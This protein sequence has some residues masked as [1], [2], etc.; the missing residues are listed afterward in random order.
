MNSDDVYDIHRYTDEQLMN[1]LNLNNPTDHELEAKIL[2]MIRRYSNIQNESG[3]KLA[4]FFNRVYEHFF[5]TSDDLYESMETTDIDIDTMDTIEGFMTSAATDKMTTFKYNTNNPIAIDLSGASLNNTIDKRNTMKNGKI[6]Y[7]SYSKEEGQNSSQLANIVQTQPLEYSNDKTGLNPLIKQT[8]KRIVNIDSQFRNKAF[9]PLSTDFTFNLSEPLKDVLSLKLYS[10]QIPYTWYTINNNYGSNFLYL[11]GVTTGVDNGLQDYQITIPTGNYLSTDFSANINASIASIKATNP[12][13]NFGTTNFSFNTLNSKSTFT[14]DIQNIYNES[15][16]Q[17]EMDQT[18]AKYLQFQSQTYPLNTI[19]STNTPQPDDPNYKKTTF[20]V[21]NSINYF[22]V[23]HYTDPSNQ[24]NT[25]TSLIKDVFK[26]QLLTTTLY[27]G[28]TSYIPFVGTL[29]K[30]NINTYIQNGIQQQP[31]LD[32]SHSYVSYGLD[33]RNKYSFTISLQLNKSK[34]RLYPNSKLCIQFPSRDQY[35]DA[36]GNFNKY[37]SPFWCNEYVAFKQELNSWTHRDVSNVNVPPY[38]ISPTMKWKS[39]AMSDD[40]IYQTAAVS[41]N[42]PFDGTISNLYYSFDTGA[43]WRAGTIKDTSNNP[44]P[45]NYVWD[46]VVIAGTGNFQIAYSSNN[47]KL[48]FSID[49]GQT[50]KDSNLNYEWICLDFAN[51]NGIIIVAAMKNPNKVYNLL[52]DSVNNVLTMSEI[53]QITQLAHS[54]NASTTFTYNEYAPPLNYF[55]NNISITQNGIYQVVITSTYIYYSSDT[56]NTWAVT[57]LVCNGQEIDT[58][59]FVRISYNDTSSIIYTTISTKSQCYIL[60][61]SQNNLWLSNNTRAWINS[62]QSFNYIQSVSVSSDSNVQV[63]CDNTYDG[64]NGQIYTS[65]DYGYTWRTTVISPSGVNAPNIQW[66]EVTISKITNG[67]YQT[68]VGINDPSGGVW[69]LFYNNGIYSTTQIYT[70]IQSFV[71]FEQKTIDTN[72]FEF[73]LDT[74]IPY[75][76]YQYYFYNLNNLYSENYYNYKYGDITIT[77]TN[78]TIQFIPEAGHGARDKYAAQPI[79]ITIPP[80]TYTLYPGTNNLLDKINAL[81]L[82]TP[83]LLGSYIKKISSNSNGYEYLEYVFNIN[84][85]YTTNDYKLVFYDVYSFVS[86]FFGA[87]GVQNITWDNTLGWILGYRDFTEYYLTAAN[88]QQPTNTSNNGFTYYKGSPSSV[89]TYTPTID[90]TSGLEV[91]SVASLTGDTSVNTT[92][93]N[94]FYIVLDDYNQNHLNDGVVINVQSE[95]NLPIPSYSNTAVESCNNNG[96]I[97]YT[98]GTLTQNQLYS[99]NKI[100]QDST[101]DITSQTTIKRH[102]SY[103]SVQDVFAFIPVKVNGQTNG[104]TYIEFGGTLQNQSRLYFGPVNIHRMSV[105]L[106][107]DKGDTLNLNNANWSFSF[108]CEQLYRNS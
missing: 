45:T 92:L 68:A 67:L 46:R 59:S 108:E 86:C 47:S 36:S 32:I 31:L 1:I 61:P 58:L 85:I 6:N 34:I 81:F 38:N 41:I 89:Y 28:I 49:Y 79:S 103:P 42:T 91:R 71:G 40:G 99:V 100:N 77:N 2:Q 30:E 83:N 93:Y 98:S 82:A 56:G 75:N 76:I 105:K 17:I 12:D 55:Y 74:N 19:Y 21:D 23:I 35:K 69:T 104:T 25:I 53:T 14:I 4:H 48:W 72:N 54:I 102:A 90:P 64:K 13:I 9:Y 63:I 106:V 62:P 3:M 84:K 10:I 87:T 78:N 11:K 8:I 18:V 20:V 73:S 16:Y 29:T 44:L 39:V 96:T 52:Y 7:Q 22:T 66:Q 94:Y 5:D 37:N 101:P 24:Y 97:T 80:G 88:V 26:V 65:S 70:P 50:W 95:A 51:T 60:D 57:T 27:Q 33:N 43:T 107:T 15:Y